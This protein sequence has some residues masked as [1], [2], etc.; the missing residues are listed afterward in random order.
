[1]ENDFRERR[2]EA[3][4][5]ALISSKATPYEPARSSG[6]ACTQSIRPNTEYCSQAELV[7][8]HLSKLCTSHRMYK[9]M[10]SPIPRSTVDGKLVDS[11]QRFPETY[12]TIDMFKIK[13]TKPNSATARC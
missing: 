9:P 4:S 8:D 10:G 7:S 6:I 11:P 12:H 1:M 3:Y 2:Y 13:Q 5:Q